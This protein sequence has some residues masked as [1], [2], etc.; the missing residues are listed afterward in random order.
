MN[1][2]EGGPPTRAWIGVVVKTAT[3][4]AAL[5]LLAGVGMAF[6]APGT[7]GLVSPPHGAPTS[8]SPASL[9]GHDTKTPLCALAADDGPGAP[10]TLDVEPVT[11][12]T[13]S[14]LKRLYRG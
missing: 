11:P 14:L 7:R 2:V 9:P 3:M 10:S 12:A 6:S 5:L 13:W 8:A 4:A 1:P